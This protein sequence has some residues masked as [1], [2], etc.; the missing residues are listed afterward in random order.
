MTREEPGSAQAHG[1]PSGLG[2]PQ[3]H[4]RGLALGSSRG[5]DRLR[6]DAV[7]AGRPLKADADRASAPG[8]TA[9]ET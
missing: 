3:A 4:A 8:H 7:H 5:T 6:G 9:A 1:A 2:A